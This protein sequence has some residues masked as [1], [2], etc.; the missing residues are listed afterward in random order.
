VSQ[1]EDEDL[2]LIPETNETGEFQFG[3]NN[4][5]LVGL[6]P[7]TGG[8]GDA[9]GAAGGEDSGGAASSGFQF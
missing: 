5:G 6:D 2:N 1:I 3:A 8:G 4:F 7:A 9:A